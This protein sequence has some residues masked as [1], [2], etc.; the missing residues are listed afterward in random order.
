MYSAFINHEFNH[1]DSIKYERKDSNLSNLLSQS[2]HPRT[3]LSYVVSVNC[4]PP[5][6]WFCYYYQ[7]NVITVFELRRRMTHVHLAPFL[8]AFCASDTSRN[9]QRFIIM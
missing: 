3:K 9:D 1:L 4:T 6:E 5:I 2:K 7:S 8:T